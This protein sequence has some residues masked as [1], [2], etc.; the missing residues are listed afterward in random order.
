LAAF[1]NVFSTKH[2]WGSPF[3][4]EWIEDV[5]KKMSI[6]AMPAIKINIISG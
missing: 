5:L 2:R 3:D 4:Q 6:A 1:S